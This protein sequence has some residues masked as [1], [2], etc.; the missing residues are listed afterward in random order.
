MFRRRLIICFLIVLVG[1]SA[2]LLMPKTFGLE[3]AAVSQ[4]LPL[5]VSGWKGYHTEPSH[6]ETKGLDIETEFSKRIYVRDS[7]DHLL[8]QDRVAGTMVLSGND[9]NNSIHRPERCLVSQ[10]FK[11]ITSSVIEIDVGADQPLKVTRLRF[12][13][14]LGEDSETTVPALMYYWFVGAD[15]L[16]HSHYKRTLHDMKYRLTHGN[17]QRWAYISFSAIFGPDVASGLAPNTETETDAILARFV[18]DTFYK[19]HKTEL[20]KG[21]EAK[22]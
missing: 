6:N 22:K 4:T 8:Q 17:N 9:M 11:Q 14:P 21:W 1:M 5:D 3:P 2:A 7:P 13:R 15:F 12:V 10:G 20:I 16:T 19:I 18:K